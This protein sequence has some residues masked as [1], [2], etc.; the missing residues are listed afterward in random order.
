MLSDYFFQI[1]LAVVGAVI[2]VTVP[3]L[4][5]D[6][7]KKIAKILAVMLIIIAILWVGYEL[8][9]QEAVNS[10][11]QMGVTSVAVSSPTTITLVDSAIPLQPADTLSTTNPIQALSTQV[12]TQLESTAPPAS[13]SVSDCWVPI[14]SINFTGDSDVTTFLTPARAGF[15]ASFDMNTSAD[16]NGS[17]RIETT[18]VSSINDPGAWSWMENLAFIEAQDSRYRIVAWIKTQNSVQSHIS[19]V[20][21]DALGN[22]V[23]KNGMDQVSSVPSISLDGTKD[24]V[25]YFSREFNPVQWDS[26]IQSLAVGVNAGWSPDGQPSIT[27][28]DAIELQIC[29]K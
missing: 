21:R 28:F 17:L 12:P 6:K 14:W 26:R 8:G 15:I 18:K 2:G 24:G 19:I 29:S 1:I 11:V 13:T 7:Q 25:I 10:A 5:N 20:G 9:K 27:W 23:Y 3:L 4:P 16:G 22:D